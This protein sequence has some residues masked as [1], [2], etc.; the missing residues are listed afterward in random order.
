MLGI[1][2]VDTSMGPA[3][4]V[5]ET[6]DSYTVDTGTLEVVLSK[7]H[8]SLFE[9]VHVDADGD[10]TYSEAELVSDGPGEMFI[11]LDDTAPGPADSGVYDYPDADFAGMEGGNW[12]RDSIATSS[13]RYY[14]SA[15]DYSISPFRIGKT[16]VTFRIDGWH[17]NNAGRDFGKYTLY[18][19]FT[20]Q[21]NTVRISHTWIMTGDPDRNFI[22]RMAISLPFATKAGTVSYG[23]GGEAGLAGTEVLEGTVGAGGTASIATMGPDAYYHNMP[24]GDAAPVSYEVNVDG[25]RVARGKGAVGW[26]DAGDGLLGIAAG[27][28]D[29]WREYPKEV[30]YENGD[31]YLYLWPDYGDKSLDLRRRYPETRGTVSEG[32][33]RAARREFGP[34]GSAV[35]LA[36]S[37][38]LFLHFHAGDLEDA[39]VD[40]RFRGF[41]KPLMPF[42]SGEY[43]AAT[44]VFGN[45]VA[46]D[47]DNYRKTENYLD[48]M[49][50]RIIRSQEE[51]GWRGMLDYGDLLAEYGKQDWELDIPANPGVFS[52]WGY[53]GWLQESYR[54]GQ[55]AFVQYF[56]S[57]R[58]EYFRAADT[59]LRHARDVDCV[60][61]DAPD[62]GP[63]PKDGEGNSLRTGA[64]HRHDQQHW[65]AYL[66]SYGIPG[67]AVAHHYYLTGDG[68][69]LDAMKEY[70]NWLLYAGSWYENYG[71]YAVLYMAL[72]TGND[73]A[74]ADAL[75]IDVTPQ[76]AFGRATYDSGMGL[77]LYD[78][79][80]NGESS[81]RERLRTWADLDE[82][83]AAFIRGYLES[84]EDSGDY[85]NRIKNDFDAA[86]PV[87]P[88]D[89][90]RY[91]WA[92]GVP[93]DFRD[94]FS[95]SV[96]PEGVWVLPLH[97]IEDIQRDGPGG[98]GNDL[99]RH[100]D[101]MAL[102]WL[103]Q[104]EGI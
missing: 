45:V 41:E 13:T 76:S 2:D 88:V 42:A 58:D 79:H 75:A 10:G 46:Y 103:M 23:F 34:A 57:G 27:V 97:V 91:G 61:W 37:T 32:W 73:R 82:S 14:A 74:I 47:P 70:I 104:F 59:W 69:D 22:R 35:G 65:G 17:R 8:F 5:D 38:D 90:S 89:K 29:F 77:M 67:I 52:N 43:N 49:M 98:M 96:M 50:A 18:L 56:R 80:T 84:Q 31:V 44:G 99:G 28:R 63:R 40:D 16:H 6:E 55:W 39:L 92:S 11:D 72:A 1:A 4:T 30:K 25:A 81:V 68:R 36:K 26:M 9:S 83:S 85:T 33:G 94:V 51:Y 86:F 53:A 48:L 60:H 12:L 71:Q 62:D 3:I 7:Q 95:E 102:M 24:P 101:Q 15:G 64:G 66:A 78:I 93:A 54:F 19:H 87:S 100:S 21:S 20:A